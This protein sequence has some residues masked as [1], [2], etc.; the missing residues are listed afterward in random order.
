MNLYLIG[1]FF[2]SNI[3]CAY[4]LIFLVCRDFNLDFFAVSR[5]DKPNGASNGSCIRIG[6]KELRLFR[7]KAFD[8]IFGIGGRGGNSAKGGK[9]SGRFNADNDGRDAEDRERREDGTG[10]SG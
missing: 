8:F 2:L 10:R 4:N 3:F 9:S 6:L 5:F 7:L 1:I